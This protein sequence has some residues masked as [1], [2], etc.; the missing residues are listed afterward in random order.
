MRPVSATMVMISRL[1]RRILDRKMRPETRRH[2]LDGLITRIAAAVT[3][4]Q[5]SPKLL[6]A[7]I[8]KRR[9][10]RRPDR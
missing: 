10:M 6:A 9:A 4:I 1:A 7:Q 5:A 2:P 8:G 3:A